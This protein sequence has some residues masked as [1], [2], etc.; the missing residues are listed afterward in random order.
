MEEEL[1]KMKDLFDEKML[2]MLHMLIHQNGFQM[3]D[4]YIQDNDRCEEL[5]MTIMNYLYY[6][7][8]LLYEHLKQH[9]K[10]KI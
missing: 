3:H 6:I 1:N 7:Y 4:H 5:I 2:Y 9:N 10:K 8:Q